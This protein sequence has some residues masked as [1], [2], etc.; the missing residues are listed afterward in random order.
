MDKPKVFVI[1]PFSDEFFES[2][3][4]IKNQFEDDFE[5][6]NAGDEDNQQ[7]IL[8]DIITPIYSADIVLADLTGLNPNVMYELGIAHSFNKKTIIITRDDLEVLP[9]DLKQ[10]RVKG[11][12]THFK[13]FYDLLEYL[14]KNFFGAIDGS[15]VFN[16]PVNDFLD[17]NQIDY[18]SLFAKEK[19]NVDIP[20]DDG[21]LDFLAG[22][23]D[24]AGKMTENITQMTTELITM[25]DGIN[26]CSKEIRRVQESGGSGTTA[27]IRKQSKKAAGFMT[28]FDEN[29]RKH[30]SNLSMLW[31]ENEKNIF[32]LLESPYVAK[33]ENCDSLIS[34]LCALSKTQV[35]IRTSN[36]SVTEMKKASLGNLGFERSLNQ[37]IRFLDEDLA[38]Y[39]SITEQ[40]DASINRILRKSKFIVG[41][42]D[43]L[44]G[45]ENEI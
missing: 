4:L 21:L 35:A 37:S 39:L 43:F 26:G 25:S 30:S 41:D 11:Y 22:I 8:A 19:I 36:Q 29:L 40:I 33:E 31:A 32:G 17:K 44:Q 14:K 2:Y 28:E 27:F 20:D 3:E 7:N 15:V 16:N 13:Q 10:Y 23:E 12:S 18:K 9:F 38:T 24:I 1:M 42:V 5:F 34:F 45:C 6:T